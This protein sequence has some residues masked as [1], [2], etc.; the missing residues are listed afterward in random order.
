MKMIIGGAYQGQIE[1][2]QE[3]Y[4]DINWINGETCE[5]SEV[6]TCQGILNF[7]AYMKRILQEEPDIVSESKLQILAERLIEKN[8]DII[9]VSDE[10]GCGL[11]PIDA[12]ERQYREQTGRIC[13]ELASYSEQVVRVVMGI[14]TIIK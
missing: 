4:K 14:G 13:T 3:Q 6:F 8:P 12:F 2:A 7:H 10:I 5:F 1:W 11:V 9:V